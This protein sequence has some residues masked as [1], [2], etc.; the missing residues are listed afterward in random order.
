M[1][2]LCETA[3]VLAANTQLGSSYKEF[4]S[5]SADPGRL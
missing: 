1:G 3:L 4:Q 5:F 2:D